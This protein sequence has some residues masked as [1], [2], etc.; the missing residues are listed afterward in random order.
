MFCGSPGGDPGAWIAGR[1][2]IGSFFFEH[3]AD[4][5]ETMYRCIGMLHEVSDSNM[6]S[7]STNAFA[8]AQ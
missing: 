2:L 1:Q 3:F 7:W 6:W 8:Q 4:Q 5:P